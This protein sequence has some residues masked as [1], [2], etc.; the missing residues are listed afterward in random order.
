MPP[1]P[2]LGDAAVH[3]IPPYRIDGESHRALRIA[4]VAVF[5]DVSKV[6]FCK[7]PQHSY[8]GGVGELGPHIAGDRG[9]VPRH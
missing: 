1:N 4:Q 7:Q 2:N 6:R 5:Y 3:Q 8:S 9:E